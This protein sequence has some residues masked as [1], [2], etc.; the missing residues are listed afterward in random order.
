MAEGRGDRV[1]IV[2]FIY[3]SGTRLVKIGVSTKQR[4]PNRLIE[5]QCGN[6]DELVLLGYMDGDTERETLLHGMFAAQHHRGEWFRL[7]AELA[8]Y[9]D[10]HA[11][12]L[13]LHDL[14]ARIERLEVRDGERYE[15]L[16]AGSL[17][18]RG[19]P[20]LT[21]L[22]AALFDLEDARVL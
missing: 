13:W 21:T 2:Y 16:V 20:S 9:I 10:T 11:S 6:P 18:L 7:D 14:P 4:L 3:A 15:E 8:R 22:D 12:E 19:G 5:L 17:L 1:S